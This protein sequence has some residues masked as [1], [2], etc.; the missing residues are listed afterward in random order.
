MIIDRTSQIEEVLQDM[1]AKSAA[2][3]EEWYW[4]YIQHQIEGIDRWLGRVGES[5]E[6]LQLLHEAAKQALA[7]RDF[8]VR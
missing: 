2:S 6:G 5:S 1:W 8:S 7:R 4:A 3:D